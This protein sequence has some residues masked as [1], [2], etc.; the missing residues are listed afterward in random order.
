MSVAGSCL[1]G[2]VAFEAGGPIEGFA[3]ADS[4]PQH[5]ECPPPLEEQ[6]PHAR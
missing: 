5:P 4:L 3:I 6:S 2:D 1:C